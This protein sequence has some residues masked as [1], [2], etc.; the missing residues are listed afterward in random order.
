[1]LLLPWAGLEGGH[2][3][4]SRPHP[5]THLGRATG[6]GHSRL[7]QSRCLGGPPGHG[8]RRSGSVGSEPPP[9]TEPPPRQCWAARLFSLGAV[10]LISVEPTLASSPAPCQPPWSLT[11]YPERRASIGLGHPPLGWEGSL[12]PTV[13][14]KAAH[15]WQAAPNPPHQPTSQPRSTP[16]RPAGPPAPGSLPFPPSPPGLHRPL[17]TNPTPSPGPPCPQ[18][19]ARETPAHSYQ[20]LLQAEPHTERGFLPAPGHVPPHG[21]GSEGPG[22]MGGRGL[23]GQK[24]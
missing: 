4:P 5:Q 16:I 23:G 15:P 18:G 17:P 12:V 2:V 13:E 21:S 8:V 1:M 14:Q 20:E 3:T 6:C 22:D 7:H 10:A 19:A 11:R 24:E 9:P